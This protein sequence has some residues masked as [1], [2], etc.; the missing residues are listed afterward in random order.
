MTE[1]RVG[2]AAR[3]RDGRDARPL[4]VHILFRLDVGGLEQLLVA[5]IRGLPAATYRHAV[6]CVADYDPAFRQRLPQEIP[7][8]ALNR[9][10]R[11]GLDAL[12]RL[13]RL[14]RQLRPDIVHTCNLAGLECQPVAAMTGVPVRVH[15]EHGWDVADLDGT[16][17]GHRWLRRALSPWVHRHVTV[18]AHLAAY[19]TQR[20]GIPRARVLHI[21]NGVDVHAFRP[22]PVSASPAGGQGEAAERPFVI[23]TVGRLTAVKDQATLLEAFARLRPLVPEQARG[24]LRLAVIGSGPLAERLATLARGLGIAGQ[25]RFAGNRWDI[26]EQLRR[27]DV[28][29]L[30][31]LA[32]GIPVTVLEAMACARPV[33]ASRVGGVPEVVVDG[34]TGTLVPAGDPQALAEALRAYVAEPGLGPRHGAAGRER[35]V[36]GF[37]LERMV[38]D[39]QALYE[40][41]LERARR[42]RGAFA[43]AADRGL[44]GRG[45][46]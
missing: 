28:F 27:L 36:A 43:R 23:G 30:P 10:G 29:A 25:V 1:Q 5:L 11:R 12:G 45:G 38:S 17:R 20:V 8:Y 15:A 22:E 35:V 9:K 44:E 14:L 4:V 32:E 26:A 46:S 37:S 42:P 21:P 19:L 3:A 24:R 34:V 41:L 6:V 13:Y 33:V 40:A 2:A 39:Y 31:S 18:S 16:H 7:V